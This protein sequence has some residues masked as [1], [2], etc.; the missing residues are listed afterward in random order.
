MRMLAVVP[1]DPWVEVNLLQTLRQ[2]Y[3]ED[4]YVMLC[5]EENQLGSRQ[6]RAQRDALNEDLVRLAG[7]LRSTGRLDVIFFIVYDDFLTVETAERLRTLGVPMVNYH[8]DMVFQW[9]RVIRTAPFFDLLAVAQMANAEHLA[10]YNPNIEWMPMAANP[11]FYHSRG[12]VGSAYQYRVSFIGSFNP[13]RRALLAECVR[14]NIMPVVFGRGW[15]NGEPCG[16]KFKWDLYKVLHDLRFY[17]MPR[18]QAEGLA[19]VTGPITRKYSRWRAFKPLV[20]PDFRG[21]CETEALPAIFRASQVNLGF[22]DTGWH[23]KK[24]VVRSEMLQCRLRDFEVPMS[25]GFYLVQEAPDHREYYV[26]GKEIE[27]WSAPEE[28]ID[29][30]KFYSSNEEAARRIREAGQKR[31]LESHTWR[32]RFDRLFLRLRALGRFR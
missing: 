8:I 27:T 3:C 26:I 21:P 13:Y 11:S 16:L 29:K 9:Y 1:P 20:G 24:S 6:W 25:G 22:S 30:V 19:S 18:W 14:R 10:A 2:H 5:P 28:L 4:L 12:G 15:R 32:H 17:A 31:A 23:S 7:S